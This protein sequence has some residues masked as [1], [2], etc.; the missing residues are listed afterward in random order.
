MD[1]VHEN[2]FHNPG[3]LAGSNVRLDTDRQV[4]AVWKEASLALLASG[5]TSVRCCV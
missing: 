4:Y 3:P 5:V 2:M 1:P